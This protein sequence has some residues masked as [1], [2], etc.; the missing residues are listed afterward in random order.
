MRKQFKTIEEFQQALISFNIEIDKLDKKYQ[1]TVSTIL[2]LGQHI[3]HLSRVINITLDEHTSMVEL[4]ILSAIN[5]TEL[6]NQIIFK[7]ESIFDL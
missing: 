5:S 3:P 6:H 1:S 2:L 4:E 7:A